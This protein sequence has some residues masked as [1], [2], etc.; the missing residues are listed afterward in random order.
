MAA[1]PL[2]FV[3]RLTLPDGGAFLLRPVQPD[4]WQAVQEGFAK[5]SPEDR[6]YRFLGG[7]SKLTDEMAQRLCTLDY[8][9]E[10]AFT[11]F[12]LS[13]V[14]PR[15]VGI[16]RLA[17]LEEPGMAEM[18]IVVL[19]A[20]RR[21]GVARTMLQHLVRWARHHR[22]RRIRSLVAADN[23][24]MRRLAEAYGCR[25]GPA[26]DEPGLLQIEFE[27]GSGNGDGV[28]V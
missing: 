28:P 16:A 7:L 10:M 1:Y 2:E 5:L 14:P 9:R 26:R 8:E 22:Y 17:A 15:G 21:R 24:P 4:D 20:W 27:I 23:G 11:L 18:A 3:E 19:P 6:R 12:D 13:A 25:I